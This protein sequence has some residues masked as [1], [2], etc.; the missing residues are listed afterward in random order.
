MKVVSSDVVKKLRDITGAGI[1]DCKKALLNSDCDIKKA[2]EELKK[3]GV[4]LAEKKFNREANEGLVN[5]IA[6]SD[7]K[8]CVILEANCE[9]DFVAR[10]EEFKFFVNKVSKYILFNENSNTQLLNNL[11]LENFENERLELISKLGENIFIK[12]FDLIVNDQGSIGFYMHEL[13]G[14]SK[15]GSIVC[16]N[17]Y[18]DS[19]AHDIAMQIVALNPEYISEQYIPLSRIESE[20]DILIFRAKEIHKDKSQ[21]VLNKIVDGQINKIINGLTLY[22]QYFIKNSKILV[23]DILL[24]NKLDIINMIRYEIIS[25]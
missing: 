5:I 12:K 6:S 3:M 9:T 11:L 17:G 10:Q 25:K 16:F 14:V 13:N 8:R 4:A 18:N 7:K 1:M 15:V 2:I 19:L 20:R 23:K 22:G 21:V 24:E